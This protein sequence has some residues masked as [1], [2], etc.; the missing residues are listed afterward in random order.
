MSKSNWGNTGK[1][2]GQ[3]KPELVLEVIK[4]S[5]TAYSLN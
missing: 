5:Q 4:N 1:R 2:G 3:L